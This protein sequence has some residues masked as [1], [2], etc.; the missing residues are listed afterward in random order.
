MAQQNLEWKKMTRKMG[1]EIAMVVLTARASALIL[2]GHALKARLQAGMEEIQQKRMEE[3]KE[4]EKNRNQCL[5]IR[6]S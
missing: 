3:R 5:T 1:R 4:R 6:M 2:A